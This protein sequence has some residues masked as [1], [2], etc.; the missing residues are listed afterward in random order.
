MTR[1]LHSRFD[2]GAKMPVHKLKIDRIRQSHRQTKLPPELTFPG[3]DRLGLG[4]VA[5]VGTR[6]KETRP[7]IAVVVG[8]VLTAN[9]DKM[10]EAR[11]YNR[12]L[13]YNNRDFAT[14]PTSPC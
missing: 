7:R 11:E 9:N 3:I 2:M 5:R 14:D 13:V 6:T 12:L 1:D 8:A 10:R 4:H